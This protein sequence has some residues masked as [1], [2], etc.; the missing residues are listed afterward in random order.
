M[1]KPVRSN[2]TVHILKPKFYAITFNDSESGCWYSALVKIYSYMLIL[3]F[4]SGFG[5]YRRL[6]QEDLRYQR[7]L[8]DVTRARHQTHHLRRASRVWPWRQSGTRQ[9]SSWGAPVFLF[10]WNGHSH[11]RAAS[12]TNR[13]VIGLSEMSCLVIALYESCSLPA[14]ESAWEVSEE[15]FEFT[16]NYFKW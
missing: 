16:F 1:Q 12:K 6:V 4:P 10:P 9:T 8:L 5:G 14:S 15:N 7:P 2:W 3:C 11:R 13:S